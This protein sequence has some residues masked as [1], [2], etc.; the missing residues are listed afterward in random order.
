M[1]EARETWMNRCM[2]L[3]LSLHQLV[4]LRIVSNHEMLVHVK[5]LQMQTCFA[6][7]VRSP[8]DLSVVGAVCANPAR[9]DGVH[10]V[11][12]DNTVAVWS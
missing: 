11:V 4:C 3:V 8:S 10:I 6:A 2:A 5:P 1:E 12:F 7:R 9:F